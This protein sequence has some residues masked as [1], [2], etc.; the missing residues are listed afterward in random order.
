MILIIEEEV[1][2]YSIC[3]LPPNKF[4]KRPKN[5]TICYV[6]VGSQ[7]T[8]GEMFAAKSVVKQIRDEYLQVKFIKHK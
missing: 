1:W 8:Q 4:M 2:H 3:V 6:F 7:R 5:P